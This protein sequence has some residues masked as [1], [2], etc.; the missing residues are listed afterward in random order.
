MRRLLGVMLL[1]L[2]ASATEARAQGPATYGVFTGPNSLYGAPGYYGTSYG[3]A[4][5][6]LTRTYSAF[7]SPYG[8][9]YGYGYP[10]PGFIPNQYGVNL[11]R[12][13][14]VA[15]GYI[16]G[17]PTAYR[18]YP[19]RVWPTPTAYGPSIGAYAPGF[20]PSPVPVW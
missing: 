3:T 2:A 7:N 10:T 6:G 17:A 11:W 8:A 1:G 14:F 5:Y 18:T 16:Y 4:S 9:G 15:P 12:P 19:V 13:G 20:G